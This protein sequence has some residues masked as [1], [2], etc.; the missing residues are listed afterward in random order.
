MKTLEQKLSLSYEDFQQWI[1]DNT[2]EGWLIE[3]TYDLLAYVGY[4]QFI[5]LQDKNPEVNLVNIS[6]VIFGEGKDL[7]EAEKQVF[8]TIN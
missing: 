6:Q 5:V 3:D 4:A 8:P 1:A 7:A 2:P